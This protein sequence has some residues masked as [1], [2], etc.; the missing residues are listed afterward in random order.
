[1]KITGWEYDRLIKAKFELRDS[2]KIDI[3]PGWGGPFGRIVAVVPS[4]ACTNVIAGKEQELY[5]PLYEWIRKEFVPDDFVD[6][7]D[8]FEVVI[9]A[10]KRPPL[11]GTWE[12]PDILSLAIKKYPY[13]P[14]PKMTVITFEVKKELDAFNVYGVFEAVSHSKFAHRAYYCFEHTDDSFEKRPEVQ[15]ILQEASVNGIGILRLKFADQSK[16][17]LVVNEVLEARERTPEAATLNNLIDA[18]F[19]EGT[20]KRIIERTGH[21]L[22]W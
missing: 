4:V 18:F 15:R 14:M 6:G 7:K 19:D 22:Y 21:N 1:M 16:Q 2:G 12:V 20:K 3:R 8:L 13:V 11:A 9:S 10:N 5:A 17:S